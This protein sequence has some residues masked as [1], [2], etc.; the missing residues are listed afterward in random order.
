[1]KSCL[2]LSKL[3]PK[4]RLFF[5]FRTW[6]I[7]LLYTCESVECRCLLTTWASGPSCD[8]V[9]VGIVVGLV[10]LVVVVVLAAVLVAWKLGRL[11][12]VGL[13]SCCQSKPQ[14]TSYPA[15]RTSSA[16]S[17]NTTVVHVNSYDNDGA[18]ARP[19]SVIPQSDQSEYLHLETAL[20]PSS[21]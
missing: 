19:E 1:M 7:S 21:M 5:F 9:C 12:S 10:V 3:R 11:P 17:L 4:Y 20:K 6:C 8:S 14:Y 2:N 18:Y 15:D 13:P 16:G